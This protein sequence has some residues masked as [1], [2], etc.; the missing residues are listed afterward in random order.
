MIYMFEIPPK[1]E[2][3]ENSSKL[4]LKIKITLQKKIL[5]KK[6]TQV[7]NKYTGNDKMKWIFFQ[8]ILFLGINNCLI[9]LTNL[10]KKHIPFVTNNQKNLDSFY[11]MVAQSMDFGFI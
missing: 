10:I 8:R 5:I 6:I 3:P 2:F 11:I 4:R 9:L 1:T 7:N